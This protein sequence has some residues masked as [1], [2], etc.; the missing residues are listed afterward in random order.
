MRHDQAKGIAM[1]GRERLAIMMSSKKHVFAIKV[2]QR[3]VGGEALFSMDHHV[4]RFWLEFYQLENFLE[5][6]ALPIIV[7]AAPARNAM[8]ITLRFDYGEFIEH[9]PTE[10]D[11]LFHQATHVKVPARRIETGNGAIVQDGP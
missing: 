10:A 3:H 4:L 6:H 1:I 9:V 2:D 5:S 7:K 8:E 11:W